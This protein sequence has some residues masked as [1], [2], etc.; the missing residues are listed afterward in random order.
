MKH[1]FLVQPNELSVRKES[2][3]T[4]RVVVIATDG[5]VI[6]EVKVHIDHRAIDVEVIEK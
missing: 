2:P 1:P 3:D 5:R 6:A 4:A